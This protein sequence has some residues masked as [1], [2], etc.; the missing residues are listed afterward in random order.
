MPL[1]TLIL[2]ENTGLDDMTLRY[3]GNLVVNDRIANTTRNRIVSC[4]AEDQTNRVEGLVEITL[5]VDER[6]FVL[7]DRY[8]LGVLRRLIDGEGQTVD[9]VR[10][11][12]GLI[13]VLVLLA[14]RQFVVHV[15]SRTV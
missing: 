9:T 1:E 3:F 6:V 2:M 12:D 11:I 15:I 4:V 13:A 14:L 8:P 5:T 7:A 10:T